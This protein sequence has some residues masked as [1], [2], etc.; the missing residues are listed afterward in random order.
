M[1]ADPSKKDVSPNLQKSAQ[2]A[3]TN[4]HVAERDLRF[5]ACR[6][7]D[8]TKL[9][10]VAWKL[11][12]RQA[13]WFSHLSV[14]VLA[15]RP[16][17][18]TSTGSSGSRG[19]A[20]RGLYPFRSEMSTSLP[21]RSSIRSLYN[22]MPDSTMFRQQLWIVSFQTRPRNAWQHHALVSMSFPQVCLLLVA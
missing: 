7:V 22:L 11:E 14:H 4:G 2:L 6:I 12:Q 19:D 16:F 8:P 20:S 1:F 9:V 3:L 13:Q 10:K 21:S 15:E 18:H 5:T 17:K